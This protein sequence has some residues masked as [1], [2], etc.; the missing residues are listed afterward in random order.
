MVL[1]GEFM[2]CFVV[3]LLR[4]Q[5]CPQLTS[6]TPKQRNYTQIIEVIIVE[7]TQKY[8]QCYQSISENIVACE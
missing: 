4:K 5:S 8:V 6:L 2:K 7:V 3:N 1:N